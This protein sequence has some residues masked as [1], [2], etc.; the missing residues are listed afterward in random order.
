MLRVIGPARAG[1][2]PRNSGVCVGGAQRARRVRCDHGGSRANASERTRCGA[3]FVRG[4]HGNAPLFGPQH[5]NFVPGGSLLRAFDWWHAGASSRGFW[6]QAAKQR[7]RDTRNK[8]VPLPWEIFG[9]TAH[10]PSF[11]RANR[12][13]W[14][15]L[16]F[17]RLPARARGPQLPNFVPGGCSL[18]HTQT[19][20]SSSS[21]A[22]LH[23]R[24][25]TI[26]SRPV[27]WRRTCRGRTRKSESLGKK[28]GK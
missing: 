25:K 15:P 2:L 23:E 9:Q 12:D 13:S 17:R 5:P 7:L 14:C 18:A 19:G 4:L 8:S 6:A 22:I 21:A 1:R 11:A 26:I 3:G 10:T 28:R 16:T 27:A 24:D 20:A